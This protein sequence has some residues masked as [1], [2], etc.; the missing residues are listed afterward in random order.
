VAVDA[1]FIRM[2][3]VPAVMQMLGKANWWYPRWLDRITPRLSVDP[4]E[5]DV[6][7]PEADL[8]SS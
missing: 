4:G 6:A 8:V 3:I 5:H 2:A 7:A 1:L